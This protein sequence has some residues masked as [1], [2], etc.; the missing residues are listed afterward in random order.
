MGNKLNFSK[1]NIILIFLLINAYLIFV[2]F[3]NFNLN[4]D[5]YYLIGKNLVN[6]KSFSREIILSNEVILEPV[7]DRV[8]FYP[9]INSLS[10]L[11]FNNEKSMVY[12]N[13]IFFLISNLIFFILIRKIINVKIA[14]LIVSINLVSFVNLKNIV[15]VNPAVLC[16]FLLV[17]LCYN[18]HKYFDYFKIKNLFLI[19]LFCTALLLTRH[20]M[21]FFIFPFFLIIYLLT[22]K[23]IC[24]LFIMFGFTIILIWSSINNYR[25]N[26]FGYSNISLAVPYVNYVLHV[27]KSEQKIFNEYV[28]L[29]KKEHYNDLKDKKKSNFY[30][31]LD[32]FY[33]KK[34]KSYILDNPLLFITTSAKSVASMY[35]FSSHP[36]ENVIISKMLYSNSYS[37]SS[38]EFLETINMTNNFS[39][40]II[41]YLI[42]IFSIFFGF[43]LLI[44]NILFFKQ[45]IHKLSPNLKLLYSINCS[46]FLYLLCT[47]VLGG[48]S[49]NDRGLTIVYNFLL[50]VIVYYFK[51]FKYLKK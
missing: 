44:F 3:K 51:D 35:I 16:N 18:V 12:V 41:Y 28:N 11:I 50:L 10:Y 2:Y 40:K 15:S 14:L 49:Y 32:K 5:D 20:D 19:L 30:N 4:I 23:K 45:I 33:K 26:Y 21:I 8:P 13:Y 36:N 29:K 46:C 43:G 25:A 31:D 48:L 39:I 37:S 27:N 24:I 17:C 9:F 34:L 1:K 38:K 22:K 47:G 7:L 42:K 6:L